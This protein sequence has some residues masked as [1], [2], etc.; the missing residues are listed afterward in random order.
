MVI[1]SRAVV[2]VAGLLLSADP[3]H[4][5]GDQLVIHGVVALLGVGQKQVTQG[6][7]SILSADHW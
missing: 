4:Q 7:R 2:V 1:T 6:P 5:F 3:V